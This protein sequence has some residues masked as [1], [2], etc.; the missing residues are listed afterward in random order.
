[1]T[2][3]NSNEF[4]SASSSEDHDENHSSCVLNQTNVSMDVDIVDDD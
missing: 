4:Q 1:M 2:D 3:E